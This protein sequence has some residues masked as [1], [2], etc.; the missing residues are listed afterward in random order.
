MCAISS[1]EV[2]PLVSIVIP[3]FNAEFYVGGAID[4]ALAQQA[5]AVE[6]IVIDDASADATPS[7]VSAIAERDGRVR[8]ERF[9]ANAGPG[10]ARNCGFAVA[11][12]QWIAV[13]DADDLMAPDRLSYLIAAG[14]REGADIVSDN[15]L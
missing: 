12:G 7:L 5:V 13:L 11:R 6:V 4:S 14:E 9:T 15:L 2:Q 10:A 8:I 3:T 1:A